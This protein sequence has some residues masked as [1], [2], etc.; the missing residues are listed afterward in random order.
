MNREYILENIST[1]GPEEL[2][3]AIN[4]NILTLEEMIETQEL[5]RSKRTEIRKILND[6]QNSE[7]FEDAETKRWS[8]AQNGSISDLESF[9]NDFPFGRY[10]EFANAR[11]IELQKSVIEKE[12]INVFNPQKNE[13]LDKIKNDFNEFNVDQIN[14]FLTN[15]IIS[16]QDLFDIG[17]PDSCISSL[18]YVKRPVL[19]NIA[20]LNE[21]PTDYTEVYFWGWQGSGKTT[22]LAAVLNRAHKNGYLQIQPGPGLLYA[23]QLKS[24][25]TDDGVAN[26]YLPAPTP[27]EETQYMK[28]KLS[29]LGESTSSER[30]IALIELSGEIFKD[31]FTVSAGMPFRSEAYQTGFDAIIRY[32]KSYNR[33]IHFF[34]IDYKE[35]NTQNDLGLG[36]ESYL[37]AAVTYFKDKKIFQDTTDIIYIVLTKSDMMR[38]KEGDFI[39]PEDRVEYAKEYLNESPRYRSFITSLKNIC[40]ENGINNG[41]LQVLP[42]SLGEVYFK[43]ICNFNSDSANE[44]VEILM[45]RVRGRGGILSKWLNR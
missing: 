38:N 40:S 18:E 36:M 44:I 26:D 34:F 8:L 22:A 45:E 31:F 10:I 1:L 35:R 41:R 9:I 15:N 4:Q 43:D 17:I 30:N 25:F 27:L 29:K 32:L 14:S 37:E 16:K 19:Q 11:F 12:N 28:L 7:V 23:N 39:K 2:A 5:D 6:V 24:I 33:K 21:L 3:I 42:F 13:I 20:S